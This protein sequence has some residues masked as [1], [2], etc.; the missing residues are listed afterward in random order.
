M[1]DELNEY[2][3][4]RV[5]AGQ[6]RQAV[7]VPS[8]SILRPD[9]AGGARDALLGGKTIEVPNSQTMKLLRLWSETFAAGK[10]KVTVDVNEVNRGWTVIRRL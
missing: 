3:S 6:L 4:D 10:V 2:T 7:V 9:S 1:S 8:A 5:E